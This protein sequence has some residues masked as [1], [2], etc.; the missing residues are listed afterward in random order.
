[1]AATSSLVASRSFAASP[2]TSRR[3]AEW[4]TMNPVLIA[5]VPSIRSRYSAVVDQS[6]GT[7]W[8]S[9]S[10]GIPSTRASIGIR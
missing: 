10:S 3:I 7:P 8:R 9:D 5:S 4:P 1:M 2:M 6:H